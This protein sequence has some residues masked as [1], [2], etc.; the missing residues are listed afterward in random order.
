[1][2][3]STTTH[4]RSEVSESDDRS[5]ASMARCTVGDTGL[6]KQMW[7]E[8]MQPAAYLGNRAP[9]SGLHMGTRFKN[10][11]GK[12]A[13]LQRL[14]VSGPEI[15]WT[16]RCAH[17]SYNPRCEK[18]SSRGAAQAAKDSGSATRRQS[19][20]WKART[21]YS[22]KIHPRCSQRMPSCDA[23]EEAIHVLLLRENFRGICGARWEGWTSPLLP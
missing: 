22:W 15:S 2:F 20:W 10:I 4:S 6:P 7:G 3:A 12:D 13:N 18:A 5:L 17:R 1:M 16:Y 19:E 8:F 23:G 14:R 11:W 9:H 21:W